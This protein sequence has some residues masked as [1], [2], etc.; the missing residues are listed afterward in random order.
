MGGFVVG[1][2]EYMSPE[3]AQGR[4]VDSRSDIFSA[5]GVFYF[6]LAGR[7]P[8]AATELPSMLRNVMQ[9]PPPPLTEAQAPESLQRILRKAL[10]K[11]PDDR[12]RQCS[13]MH[14]DLA[15][16]RR[17]YETTTNR[18]A[19]AA[20]DRYR[21]ILALIAERRVLGR[22]LGVAGIEAACNEALAS[23][24]AEFPVFAEHA[25]PGS[26]FEPLDRQKAGEALTAIQDRHNAAM[27]ALAALRADAVDSIHRDRMA[28][29][30]PE[31][32]PTDTDPPGSVLDKAGSLWRRLK[33]QP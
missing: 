4:A 25:E 5:A 32:S 24:A 8:F 33:G 26:L 12:Y 19:Q 9:E 11:N 29:G 21:Q 14:A 30:A 13:E 2:P 10:A 1:T 22:A 20:L 16:V 15:Q 3:Q 27:A 6:M 28:D 7:S 23:L 17:T 31:D 18:M